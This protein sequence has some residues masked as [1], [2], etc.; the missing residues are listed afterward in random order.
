MVTLGTFGL[1]L[2]DSGS[3]S[4][5]NQRTAKKE[6]KDFSFFLSKIQTKD[7]YQKHL[8]SPACTTFPSSVL[9]LSATYLTC[10]IRCLLCTGLALRSAS[11]KS[12]GL[13]I[14]AASSFLS[15]V[16]IILPLLQRQA[17]YVTLTACYLDR[18][19]FHKRVH[20]LNLFRTLP[21]FTHSIFQPSSLH[22]LRIS[23]R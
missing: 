21:L 2:K 4:A 11:R 3:R 17:R 9:G 8:P 13:D 16:S 5:I 6:L 14:I 10:D 15:R 1:L 19:T 23:H 7:L 22:I 20:I 12:A 18:I